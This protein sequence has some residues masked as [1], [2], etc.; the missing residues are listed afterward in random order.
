MI[1]FPCFKF[2]L[3]IIYDPKTVSKNY[4][5]L[6]LNYFSQKKCVDRFIISIHIKGLKRNFNIFLGKI[7]NICVLS[8]CIDRLAFFV[9]CE[10]MLMIFYK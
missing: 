5:L 2:L 3:K 9:L 7:Q 6:T 4:F 1:T 8:L 10:L